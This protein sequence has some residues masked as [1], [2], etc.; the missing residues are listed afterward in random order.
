[1]DAWFEKKRLEPNFPFT[2]FWDNGQDGFG[3][4]WHDEIEIVYLL[5]GNLKVGVNTK[6]YEMGKGDILLV[7]SGDIHYFLSVQN[8]KRIVIQFSLSI[9]ENFTSIT[10]E[11]KCISPIFSGSQ[12]I[13]YCWNENVKN[14]IEEQIKEIIREHTEKQNGYKLAIKARLFDLVVLLLR[15]VPVETAQL[16]E[17]TKQGDTLKRLECIFQ[18]IEDNYCKDISLEEAASAAGL[19][20]FYFSR[21]FKLNT[22]M[23]F[24]QYLTNYKLTKAE[25]LLLNENDSITSISEKSGFN[26]IKSFNRTFKLRNGVSPSQYRKGKIKADLS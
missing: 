12:R 7:A 20:V 10:D 16:K 11:R 4:H 18:N 26:S 2:L 23:T 6:L 14:D 13:S 19:S 25:W 9:F 17:E 1:M 24:I 5:E 15:E 22:G 3:P 21:F 8:H